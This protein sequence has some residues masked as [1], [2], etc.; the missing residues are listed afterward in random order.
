[1]LI[2]DYFRGRSQRA[3]KVLGMGAVVTAVAVAV[4]AMTSNLSPTY[5]HVAVA[6]GAVGVTVMF[7]ALLYLDLT[8]CPNCGKR[9]GIQIANQYGVGRRAA[10]CLFCGVGFDKGEVRN[11]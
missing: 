9:L 1:V 8:R 7:G 10:F 11:P 2:R 3:R 5:T 4:F 6:V